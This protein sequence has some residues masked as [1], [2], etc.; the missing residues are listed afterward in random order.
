MVTVTFFEA[1]SLD[2]LMV[3]QSGLMLPCED[4]KFLCVRL[5]VIQSGLRPSCVGPKSLCVRLDHG[6]TVRVKASLCGPK[7][8]VC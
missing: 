8:S 5:D 4:P 2:L 6:N 7:V 1:L 3:S